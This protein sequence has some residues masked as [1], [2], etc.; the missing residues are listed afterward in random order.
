MK[1]GQPGRQRERKNSREWQE[2]NLEGA[3]EARLSR[4]SETT[5]RSPV[6]F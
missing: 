2:M 4:G 3:A 5:V 6:L 1:A